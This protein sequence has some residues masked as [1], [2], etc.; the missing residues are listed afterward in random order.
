LW[1]FAT[2]VASAIASGCGK[3]LH[4]EIQSVQPIAH[5]EKFG[6]PVNDLSNA[7]MAVAM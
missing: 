2:G 3:V 1:Q 5:H 4:P 6:W 7:G